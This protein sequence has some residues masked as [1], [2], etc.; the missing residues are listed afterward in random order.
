VGN[1]AKNEIKLF[2]LAL[3]LIF[4]TITHAQNDWPIFRGNAQLTG[5]SASTLPEQPELLW[6]FEANGDIEGSPV[7]HAGTVYATA[8]DSQLY[9][10]DLHSGKL[11]WKYAALA[12]TK[13]SPAVSNGVVYFGDESGAFHAVDLATGKRKWLFQTEAGVI[14]SA[15]FYQDRVLFGSY[16][17]HLYCLDV[18]GKLQWKLETDGYIHATPA[19]FGELA[20]VAGCDGLFRIVRIRDG[21]EVKTAQAGA[22]VAASTAV[23]EGRAYVGTFA[24]RVLCFDL[25]SAKVLWEYDHP[26]RDFPFFASA[27][28]TNEIVIACGRDKIVHA[29]D[30]QDGKALWTHSAKTK[31]EA[32][33]VIVDNRV[34]I[35]VANG[36]LLGLDLKTGRALWQFESGSSF[37]A[38]PAVAQGKLIIGSTDGVIY[39]FGGK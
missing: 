36:D 15:N 18:Q 2:A 23:L 28:V 35:A 6:T 30:P 31:I 27:A 17:N 33:P 39:C 14:S 1:S 12:E 8:L 10:L 13:A 19:I 16:D 37:V 26:Q 38:S 34:F 20:I 3:L 9:A 24:N 25:N 5:V 22:Y 21:V 32:S 29:L 7:I 11:Q 4:N